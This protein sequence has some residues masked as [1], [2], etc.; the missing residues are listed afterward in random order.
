MYRTALVLTIKET[1][2]KVCRLLRLS[3]IEMHSFSNILALRKINN[4][5]HIIILLKTDE[6]TLSNR[7]K[8]TKQ[9]KEILLLV[10]KL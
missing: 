10:I 6:A 5:K 4:I 1:K 3:E 7:F 8:M 2:T 9:I